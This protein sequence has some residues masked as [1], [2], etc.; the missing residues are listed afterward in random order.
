[1]TRAGSRSL[2][3]RSPARRLQ[4]LVAVLGYSRMVAVRFATDTT[5]A[6]TLGLLVELLAMLGGAPTEV[7]SDRD[8][9]LVAR[10]S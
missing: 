1:M 7:L 3:G 5:R 8:P 10:Q 4:A 9:A 6:T 2:G